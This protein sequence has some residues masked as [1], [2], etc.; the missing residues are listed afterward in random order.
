MKSGIFA[1]ANIGQ[2][3]VYVGE[4]HHLKTRWPQLMTQFAQGKFPSTKLQ[5]AWQESANERRFTFH[6]AKQI[7][8]DTDILGYKQFLRDTSEPVSGG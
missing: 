4:T 7:V 8:E 3:R 6:T 2:C 5:R 1:V